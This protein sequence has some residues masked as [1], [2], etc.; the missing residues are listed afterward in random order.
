MS[1]SVIIFGEKT[2]L[3]HEIKAVSSF[4]ADAFTEKQLLKMKID[5]FIFIPKQQLPKKVNA[6]KNINFYYIFLYFSFYD[7]IILQFFNFIIL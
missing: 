3:N 5:F 6:P 7:F 2:T 1:I 4:L